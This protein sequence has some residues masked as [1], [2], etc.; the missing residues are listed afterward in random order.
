MLVI[1]LLKGSFSQSNIIISSGVFRCCNYGVANYAG[2][3]A[4]VL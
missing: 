1:R 4:V 2:S 3:K